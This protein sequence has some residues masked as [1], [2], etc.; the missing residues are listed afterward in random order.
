M[1]SDDVTRS[2]H[3]KLDNANDAPIVMTSSVDSH[4]LTGKKLSIAFG[5]M[6]LALLCTFTEPDLRAC[7]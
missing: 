7:D 1:A 4:L 2:Q 3:S 6:L 5:A